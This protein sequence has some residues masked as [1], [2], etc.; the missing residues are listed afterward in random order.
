MVVRWHRRIWWFESPWAW[1]AGITL[2]LLAA[3]F[4]SLNAR[5][6]PVLLEVAQSRTSNCVTAAIDGAVAEQALDYG[7]LVTLERSEDGNIVALTSN[8]AQANLLRAQLLEAALTALEDLES[9]DIQIPWGVIS[10]WDILSVLG[11]GVTVRVVY[12]GTASGEFDNAFTEA[13]INQT[14][15]QIFFV[16]EADVLI[17]LP[18][19]QLR[20]AVTT[21]VCVAETILVGKVP[22]TYLNL[23]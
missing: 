14:R 13:G 4:C 9:E 21:K 23:E 8:M 3:L 11:S 12:T 16:L 1:A 20:T 6:G 18:G 7:D 17:L 5:L 22:D 15:H 10:G 19:R 2:A